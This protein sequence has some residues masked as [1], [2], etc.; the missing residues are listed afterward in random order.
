MYAI[1]NMSLYVYIYDINAISMTCAN[2]LTIR[3]NK[4]R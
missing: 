4:M 3:M 2:E 1:L